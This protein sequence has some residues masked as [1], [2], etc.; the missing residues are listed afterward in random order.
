[1]KKVVMESVV[2]TDDNQFVGR[3]GDQEYLTAEICE[4]LNIVFINHI[5]LDCYDLSERKEYVKPYSYVID[6]NTGNIVD[7]SKDV[8][9][10]LIVECISETD[11]LSDGS[12][13]EYN[14]AKKLVD[15]LAHNGFNMSF[16][17]AENFIMK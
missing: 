2:R 13:H 11:C 12:R 17:D 15:I 8:S 4:E 6:D 10:Q 14:T 7:Q 5:D 1:M 3:Y 16:E 9:D